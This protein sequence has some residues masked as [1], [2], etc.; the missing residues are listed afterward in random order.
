MSTNN[1]TFPELDDDWEWWS[2]NIGPAYY[3]HWFGTKVRPDGYDGEIFWEDP[4]DH[5]VAIYPIRGMRDDGDPD[6]SE[7]P[8]ITES[9]DT[10]QE[11]V[12]AVPQL[13]AELTS[14]K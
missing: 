3:T 4:G 10:K 6:V 9:F 1:T 14:N 5:H 2:G 12:D 7:Y 11:A 13:I 8:D